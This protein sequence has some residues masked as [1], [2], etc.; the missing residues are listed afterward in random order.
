MTGFGRSQSQT[1][2]AMPPER[3]PRVPYPPHANPSPPA[4]ASHASMAILQQLVRHL[5]LAYRQRH[6][7]A[8]HPLP[9]S[10]NDHG[11]LQA[12]THSLDLAGRGYCCLANPLEETATLEATAAAEAPM[13]AAQVD[14]AQANK[15]EAD[16]MD[17]PKQ[18]A[19]GSRR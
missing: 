3:N 2:G 18:D 15:T 19:G 14:A 5:P 11:L 17:S 13:D 1:G 10:G 6:V 16:S 9:A 4:H 12:L 8:I 7:P